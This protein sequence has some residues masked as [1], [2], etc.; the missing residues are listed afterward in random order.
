MARP[1]SQLRAV[2]E[3]LQL[4]RTS[5][6]RVSA[7]TRVVVPINARARAV[8]TFAAHQWNS[9]GRNYSSSGRNLVHPWAFALAATG[10]IVGSGEVEDDENIVQ[11]G[12]DVAGKK[13]EG[14]PLISYQEVSKHNCKETGIWVTFKEGVYDVTEFIS[15]HPGG[16]LLLVAAGKAIDPF[17]TVYTIHN[18][19]ETHELL[20]EMRIGNFD[21]TTAPKEAEVPVGDQWKDEPKIRHPALKHN[22]ER[23]FN[24]EP[25]GAILTAQFNTP[26]DLFYV[27]NHFPVPKIDVDCYMLEITGKDMGTMRLSL[28]DLKSKF[29]Q[30]TISATIQCAGNRRSQMSAIKQVR[31]LMWDNASIGNA[32]WTG[33]LLR[34]V[35]KYAGLTETS[36]DNV[37]HVQFEGLDKDIS[38][39][40]YGASIPVQTAMNAGGDVLLAYKMNGDDLPL[41]HGYPLR[42]VVPGT[43]GARNVKWLSRIVLSDVESSSLWQQKDYKLFPPSIDI[44]TVDYS[45][46]TPIQEMPVQSAICSPIPGSSVKAS[47]GFVTVKGYAWSGGGRGISRVHVSVNGGSQWHSAE[48][49]TANQ[50]YNKKWAWTLWEV[51]VPIPDG[52]TGLLDICC[53]A[54]DSACNQQPDSVGPIW[55][56]R[57]LSNNAWHH[58]QIKITNDS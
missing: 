23:P 20:E 56:F 58:V 26:N 14:L 19:V 24:A 41:D 2:C 10:L 22:Q 12:A 3:R 31:G 33:V 27:R 1:Y 13:R 37:K 21:L 32:T 48:L 30:H 18:S 57:G 7:S 46:S 35:L 6:G 44:S 54:T 34:D 42:V 9:K 15:Q 8:K 40:C 39:S 28:E 49:E 11:D 38:G 45:S 16:D 52:H 53:K 50:E 5:F 29:P 43:V 17:W 36:C 55:N 51:S 4:V 25:P 47:D